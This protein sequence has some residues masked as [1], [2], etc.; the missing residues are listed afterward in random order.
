MS[1]AANSWNKHSAKYDS[2]FAPTLS[3]FNHDSLVLFKNKFQPNA[4]VLEVACGSGAMT[5]PLAQH[6]FNVIATDFSSGMLTILKKKLSTLNLKV[7]TTVEDGETLKGFQNDA[8]DIVASS[9]GIIVFPNRILGWESAFRVLKPNGSLLAINWH[10]DSEQLR[11]TKLI[12]ESLGLPFTDIEFFTEI[13]FRT[14]VESCGFHSIEIYT[15]HHDFVFES[16]QLF[17]DAVCDNPMFLRA[18]SK[19]GVDKTLEM[20]SN[21]FDRKSVDDFLKSP[22]NMLGKALIL[23][24]KK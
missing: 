8:F 12:I 17:F 22:I 1:S 14:E 5:I 4:N 19:V 23:H 10:K 16:G 2:E 7:E 24:A 21:Y 6:G 11:F 15:T 3:L 13:G 18:V 9:F 20:A